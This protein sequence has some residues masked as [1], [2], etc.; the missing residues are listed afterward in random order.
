VDSFISTLPPTAAEQL[1]AVTERLNEGSGESLSHALTSCRRLLATVA[2]V[3]FPPQSEPR[4]DRKGKDRQVG[5]EHYKN[6]LLAFLEDHVASGG[7]S[8][9]IASQ[10]DH[11]AARLDAVYEKACKG[12]HADVDQAEAR[13]VIIQTYLFLAEVARYATGLPSALAKTEDI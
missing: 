2:D 5:A 10:L 3:V 11:L 12:V 13:L 6:R 4:T 1:V 7:T 9:I 8:D